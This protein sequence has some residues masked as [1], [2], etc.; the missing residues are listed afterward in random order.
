MLRL[1]GY[2]RR[3]NSNSEHQRSSPAPEGL[4]QALLGLLDCF[5]WQWQRVSGAP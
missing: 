5:Q 3:Q 2:R 4:P 1:V